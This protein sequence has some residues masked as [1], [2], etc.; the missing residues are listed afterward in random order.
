MQVKKLKNNALPN[1]KCGPF[2]TRKYGRSQN[3]K[4][5]KSYFANNKLQRHIRSNSEKTN[6]QVCAKNFIEKSF[7]K[8]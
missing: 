3:H 6:L 5:L 2:K 1:A 7:I 4:S 8:G